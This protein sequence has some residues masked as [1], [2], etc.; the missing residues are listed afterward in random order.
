MCP[1]NEGP[2][3]P[4]HLIWLQNT[5]QSKK[6]FETSNKERWWNLVHQQRLGCKIFTSIFKIYQIDRFQ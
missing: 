3:S 5:R 4:E 1:C 2:Q 6:N